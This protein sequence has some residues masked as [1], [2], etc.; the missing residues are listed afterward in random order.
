[1]FRRAAAVTGMD[2]PTLRVRPD[3]GRLE[4]MFR[5][6]RGVVWRMLRCRGLAPDLAADTTQEVFLIAAERMDD[7]QPASERAFL[8]GTALRLAHAARR[9]AGRFQLAEDLDVVDARAR[10]AGEQGSAIE[11]LNLALSRIDPSLVEV[12]VLFEVAEFSSVEIAQLLAIPTGT[13]ASRLRR[14]REVFR[15]RARR[16]ELMLRREESGS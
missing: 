2:R 13:V 16:I 4:R 6:H 5:A 10:N 8:I 1:M 3:P 9:T 14:A 15:D 7:I 11:L 12:F